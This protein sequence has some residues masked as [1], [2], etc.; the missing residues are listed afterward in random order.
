MHATRARARRAPVIEVGLEYA[1]PHG[2]AIV[3]WMARG[4]PPP[5][6]PPP[7]CTSSTEEQKATVRNGGSACVPAVVLG[8]APSTS[9]AHLFRMAVP[10]VA[11]L[12]GATLHLQGVVLDPVDGIRLTN[13]IADTV[14]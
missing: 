7:G 8:G 10:N 13:A 1:T 4:T 2:S 5:S 14:Q 11:A 9:P 3:N 12:A 6:A